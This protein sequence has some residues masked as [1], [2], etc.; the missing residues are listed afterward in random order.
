[1]SP[2]KESVVLPAKSV[3][4]LVVDVKTLL[5]EKD[6]LLNDL[7]EAHRTIE[8]L[9]KGQM[10]SS[11]NP[12]WAQVSMLDVSR[13]MI[14]KSK[15][16]PTKPSKI[17][18][19]SPAQKANIKDYELQQLRSRTTEVSHGG[20]RGRSLVDDAHSWKPF[21]LPHKAFRINRLIVA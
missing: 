11:S 1:M 17:S 20:P 13:K 18:S 2:K 19:T 14:G 21:S 10:K 6:K 8:Q 16:Q 3:N 9:K 15:V 12:K 5:A 4:K 7:Q